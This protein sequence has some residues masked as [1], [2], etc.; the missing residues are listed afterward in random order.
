VG[1]GAL[2]SDPSLRAEARSHIHSIKRGK[3]QKGSSLLAF[4]YSPLTSA[5][6]TVLSLSLRP[7]ATGIWENSK[8]KFSE[9]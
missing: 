1:V 3:V 8:V 4:K 2:R 9:T 5:K 7:Q 6:K